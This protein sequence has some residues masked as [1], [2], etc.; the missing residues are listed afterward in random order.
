MSAI[1]NRITL[2]IESKNYIQQITAQ[3]EYQQFIETSLDILR[4]SVVLRRS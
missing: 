4:E 1:N 3:Q 2:I